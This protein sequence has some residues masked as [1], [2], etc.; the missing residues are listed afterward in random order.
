MNPNGHGYCLHSSKYSS[1]RSRASL[2]CSST[3][4][5]ARQVQ[6]LKVTVLYT[7]SWEKAMIIT[8]EERRV[9]TEPL[10]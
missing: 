3:P 2:F 4:A 1:V 5:K 10:G 6:N 8:G 9:A 7:F